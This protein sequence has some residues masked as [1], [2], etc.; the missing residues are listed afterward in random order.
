M[1][2][3]IADT[4]A[5]VT[6]FTVLGALNEHYIAGMTWSEV[7]RSRTIGAPLMVLTARPYG[8]WRDWLIGRIAPPLPRVAADALALLIFQVPIYAAI[9][10]VSGASVAG[11]A[12][13]SASFAVL[14]LI[15]GRPY[16]LWLDFV[17]ARF[18][19]GH[20]GMTPMTLGD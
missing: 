19:L 9:L 4:L 16:G 11:V 15:V 8:I 12:Q 5:L 14:M 3:F 6:F 17:R 18:G 1:R 7:A 10:W 2:T 20:G 13:G